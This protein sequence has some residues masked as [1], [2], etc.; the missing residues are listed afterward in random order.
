MQKN[1]PPNYHID[2]DTISDKKL[3]YLA[4]RYSTPLY[5]YDSNSIKKYLYII[6]ELNSKIFYSIKA[7]PNNKIIDLFKN[8]DTFFEA[9]S[10]GELKKILK[11]NIDLSKAIFIGPAK[12]ESDLEFA[13]KNS[14]YLIV[15]ESLT[16]LKRVEKI[17]KKLNKQIDILVRVNPNFNSG[18]TINMSGITQF[19][20]EIKEVVKILEKNYQ[21]IKIKGLHFYLGTNILDARK[22]VDNTKKIVAISKQ[23]IK[24]SKSELSIIDIGG[25]FGVPYYSND[26]ELDINYLIINLNKIFKTNRDFKFF[27]ELGRFLV[28]KS[29]IF[30]TQVVDIK[31]NFNKKFVLVDGGTNFFG[32]NSKFGGFRVSPIKILNNEKE[33]EIV[34]IVGNLCT[35]SDILANNILIEKINIGDYIAFYQA[36][37]YSFSASPINFLTHLLPKEVLV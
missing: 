2:K 3:L 7:N 25:G 30:I 33:K 17:T 16:E 20:I 29:G 36:G 31:I 26:K 11:H 32:L 8:E 13:I 27:V 24:S 1:I 5:I 4:N 34:T 10:V 35:S 9:V 23:I 15:I 12:K 14:I 18:A 6:R 21:N 22:I 28:A 19:G 37:A